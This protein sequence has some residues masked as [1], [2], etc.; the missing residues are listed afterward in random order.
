[1]S[2]FVQMAVLPAIVL[3]IY[4]YVKDRVEKEPLGLLALLALMGAI[5]CFPAILGETIT[6][7]IL[8]RVL[9][10]GTITY[11]FFEAFFCVALVEELCK[12]YFLQRYTWDN[13]NFN[14]SFDGIIYSVFVSL[15]FAALENVKYLF[16]YGPSVLLSR[17]LLSIPGHMTFSI[18]MGLYYSRARKCAARG[19]VAGVTSNKTL[20]LVVSVLLHGFYDFCLMSGSDLLYVLFFGFVVLLDIVSIATIRRESKNDTPIEGWRYY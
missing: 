1:M 4:V 13:L 6:F 17:A 10:S 14:C 2:I 18:F 20:A 8:D 9:E 12:Y 7:G 19:D 11:A 15:G 5:S 16:S 3:M